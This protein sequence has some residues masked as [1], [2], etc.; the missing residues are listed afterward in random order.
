MFIC[1]VHLFVLGQ[2]VTQNKI[3]CGVTLV[4]SVTYVCHAVIIRTWL[5]TK[6]LCTNTT[7]ECLLVCVTMF[8]RYRVTSVRRA[9][10]VFMDR[11]RVASESMSCCG[12]SAP[13]FFSKQLAYVKSNTLIDSTWKSKLI[14][15]RFCKTGCYTTVLEEGLRQITKY[16][17]ET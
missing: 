1:I 14:L 5:C 17:L 4:R 12:A 16:L 10:R 2:S 15:T 6:R 9:V 7:V 8:S 3:F 13:E 11:R